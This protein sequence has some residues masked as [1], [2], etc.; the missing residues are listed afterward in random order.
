MLIKTFTESLV[1][2]FL[3]PLKMALLPHIPVNSV[4]QFPEPRDA[5]SEQF[6]GSLLLVS[7]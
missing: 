2:C 5:R 1:L 4:V 6:L 7:P 3:R